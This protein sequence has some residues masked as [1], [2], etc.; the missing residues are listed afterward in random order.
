MDAA[1]Q[2]EF[3]RRI[4]DIES[5]RIQLVD[6]RETLRIARGRIAERRA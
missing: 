2:A 4:D 6:G 1:W 5:G 3:R